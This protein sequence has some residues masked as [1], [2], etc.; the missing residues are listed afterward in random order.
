[1][2]RFWNGRYNTKEY[3]YGVLPNVF[4]K[5]QIAKLQTGKLLLPA[6]GEGR[7]AVFAAKNG[8]E[9]TAFDQ[10]IE[11][12]KKAEILAFESKVKI[13]YDLGIVEEITYEPE[14][15]DAVALI[16]AHF[17]KE[18]REKHYHKISSYL[19]KG[20]ALI[21]EC[22]SEKHIRNQQENPYAGGPK[23]V[24]MLCDLEETK[25]ELSEFDF[26]I[27]EETEIVLEEGLY[28]KGKANVIRILARKKI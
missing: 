23:D 27:A 15:F 14:S 11:G 17:P 28:H 19:K 18:K 9:V 12:K 4:F 1:M 16:F 25:S 20:G 10:S 5:N 13:H 2:D 6:E 3:A 26:E 24:S 21:M 22:F 8:W 7:N